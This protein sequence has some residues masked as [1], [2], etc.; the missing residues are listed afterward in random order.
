[1]IRW[2]CGAA[3]DGFEMCDLSQGFIGVIGVRF[4]VVLGVPKI[5]E[6]SGSVMHKGGGFLVVL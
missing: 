2:R 1:M 5:A 4:A 3:A 6:F